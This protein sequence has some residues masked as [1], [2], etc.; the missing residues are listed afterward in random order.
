MVTLEGGFAAH[1]SRIGGITRYAQ[2]GE[3]T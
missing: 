1:V 2:K 3:Q